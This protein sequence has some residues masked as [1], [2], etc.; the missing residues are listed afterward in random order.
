L[1]GVFCRLLGCKWQLKNEKS[2]LLRRGAGPENDGAD[3]INGGAGLITHG[4]TPENGGADLM[5]GRATLL[6]GIIGY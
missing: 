6:S 1:L 2:G 5:S 4:A 3:P